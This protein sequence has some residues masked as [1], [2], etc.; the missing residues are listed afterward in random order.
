M[1]IEVASR[2][3]ELRKQHGLSQEQLAERL[4]ISRQ[5]VSKWERAESSPDTDNLIAL[6]RLYQ[7]SL[8][9]LLEMTP[10][11]REDELYARTVQPSEPELSDDPDGDRVW[12][13]P[14]SASGGINWKVFPY[15][16]LV[17]IAYLL[18]GFTW[19]LWHPAW[20]LFMTIPMYY[21]AIEGDH[22]NLNKIPYPLLVPV[23]YLIIGFAWDL[24]HPGWM[25][26]LTIPLYYTIMG[27]SLKSGINM[28]LIAVS[29][30]AV[31]SLFGAMLGSWKGWLFT[32]IGAVLCGLGVM[33]TLEWNDR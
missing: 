15:P 14:R 11:G 17:V 9:E 16:V 21:T 24:W 32:G 2:L 13:L 22:F 5:A 10:E 25:L 20:L 18:I 12:N 19:D 6:A 33:Q 30:L 7:V 1:N 3:A 29:V 23:M 31:F 8:D 28:I 4:N 26:F 27:R